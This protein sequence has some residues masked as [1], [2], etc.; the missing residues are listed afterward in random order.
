MIKK[1]SHITL[2]VLDQNKAYDIYVNKLG[3]KVH[4]DM[5]MDDGFRWLTV[6]P[7]DQ[8]DLEIVLS[9]PKPAVFGEEQAK[10]IRTLLEQNALG[11]G[12]WEADDCHKSYEE[13]KAKGI[14]FL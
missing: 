10:V 3:C 4:T 1:M 8:P 5:T 14:E 12:V 2:Y 7:P 11:S 9:E 6:S 13:L